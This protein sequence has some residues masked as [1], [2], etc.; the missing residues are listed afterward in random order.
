[1]ASLLAHAGG[2]A[3]QMAERTG[4]SVASP[5][6][7]ANEPSDVP[8]I[9][10]TPQTTMRP[11]RRRFRLIVGRGKRERTC[12]AENVA[13]EPVQLEFSFLRHFYFPRSGKVHS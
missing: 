12:R 13:S 6:R 3:K 1:M 2:I 11:G 7:R 8:P 9:P 5:W 4:F 10:R